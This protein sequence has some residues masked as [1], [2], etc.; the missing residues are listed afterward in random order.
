M[1][2]A[3]LQAIEDMKKECPKHETNF[4]GDP[5]IWNFNP[6]KLKNTNYDNNV[7]IKKSI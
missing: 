7:I 1:N 5:E 2:S 4:H 6:N 3:Q